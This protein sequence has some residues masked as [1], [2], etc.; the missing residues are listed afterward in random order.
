MS[1]EP[2]YQGPYVESFI[3]AAQYIVRLTAQQN[4]L[5]EF[6]R[7]IVSYFKAEW[8]AFARLDSG[9]KISLENRVM[10][11]EDLPGGILSEKVKGIIHD[12]LET[13]FLATETVLGSE[14]YG[15]LFLPL[16]E[17]NRT[18]TVLLIGHKSSTPVRPELLNLYL[19]LTGIAGTTLDR[20]SKERQL[21]TYQVHLEDLVKERTAELQVSN[22]SLEEEIAVRLQAEAALRESEQRWATILSS[23]GDAVIA[24]DV[25]GRVTFMNAVAERLTGWTLGQAAEKPVEEVFNIINQ[26]TR[27]RAEGPVCKVLRE[28]II[29]GPDYNALLVRKDGTEV[30]IDDSGAPIKDRE[31][32]ITGLVLVFRDI[33]ERRRTEELLRQSEARRQVVE[34]VE[35]ERRRLYDVLETLPAM[36]CLLTPDYGVAFANRSSRE[37]FAESDGRRCYEYRFGLSRPCDFCESYQVLETGRPHHWE[38]TTPDGSILDAYDF[39]FID[40]DGSP[41]ILEMDIDITERKKAEENLKKA[42]DQVRYFAS[43]SLTIQEEERKRIAGELHDSTLASM[44]AMKIGIEKITAETKRGESST[45]SLQDLASKVSEIIT[46]VRRIMVDLRP[47]VLDDLGIVAAMSWFCR[48]YQKTYPHISVESHIGILESEVPDPLRTPIFRISQ[49][50]MNNISKYS[51]AS[52]VN[53]SLQKKAEKITLIIKDNGEGFDPKT[54]R[55]GLGLSTMRERAQLSGGFFDLESAEGKGTIIRAEWGGLSIWS[56]SIQSQKKD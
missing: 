35:A 1:E 32:N 17:S 2:S 53:I 47:A 16:P 31:G 4:I 25:E 5:E 49:E 28:G 26:E 12:V 6:G 15:V 54:V 14:S 56:G 24:T 46:E 55:K 36:I 18:T 20:I 30:P 43:Q 51:Q 42:H 23:V 10:G 3:K 39:P 29:A 38:V 48:E 45:E 13:G 27:C 8:V 50:A 9:G 22:K 40:A 19:A 44:A 21:R 34:A 37:K 33:T 41:L 11:G 7:L 52:L